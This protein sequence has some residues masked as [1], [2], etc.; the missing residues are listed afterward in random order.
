MGGGGAGTRHD[1]FGF[2]KSFHGFF[3]DRRHSVNQSIL[4]DLKIKFTNNILIFGRLS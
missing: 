4:G 1:R 3:T 2:N